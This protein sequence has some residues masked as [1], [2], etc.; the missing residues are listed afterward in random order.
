MAVVNP[1]RYGCTKQIGAAN[2]I[3]I[4]NL[5]LIKRSRFKVPMLVLVRSDQCWYVYPSYKF[6]HSATRV[7]IPVG[8]GSSI[9]NCALLTVLLNSA[10]DPCHPDLT[11]ANH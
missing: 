5:D 1:R 7:C 6:P 11:Y 2:G 10:R 8:T 9:S 4:N 3:T